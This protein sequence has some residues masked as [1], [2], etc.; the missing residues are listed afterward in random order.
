MISD[1]R[2]DFSVLKRILINVI[3]QSKSL[4]DSDENIVLKELY[5]NYQPKSM[6]DENE[7]SRYKKHFNDFYA[8]RCKKL[9]KYRSDDNENFNKIGRAHV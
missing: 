6:I 1:I 5:K 9:S 7:L 8:E 2:V 3:Q 4:I